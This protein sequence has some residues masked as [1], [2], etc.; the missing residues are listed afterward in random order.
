MSN[1]RESQ[2]LALLKTLRP[3]SVTI[4]DDSHQ[5]AGHNH[6]AKR[7]G[8]HMRVKIISEA[9]S[10][11]SRIERHRMVQDLLKPEFETGLHSLQIE[12]KTPAE[13]GC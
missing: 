3:V 5:H 2:I 13:S 12:A 4:H 9:F 7:G 6:A 1:D 8:T 11:K 10:G